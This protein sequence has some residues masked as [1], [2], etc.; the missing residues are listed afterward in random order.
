MNNNELTLED[1]VKS[2]APTITLAIQQWINKQNPE[3]LTQ[4]VH[5]MLNNSRDEITAKLLGMNKRWG[6]E[7]EIDHCNGRN[8]E[9]VMGDYLKNTQAA[10]IQTW[11]D[12]LNLENVKPFTATE[13]TKLRGEYRARVIEQVRQNIRTQADRD[14]AR[15]LTDISNTD[16]VANILKTQKLIGAEFQLPVPQES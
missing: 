8:G 16:F 5:G 1:A 9:S 12:S 7:W 10:A 2:I 4:K 14:A 6:G 13:L 15:L 11:I 3:E